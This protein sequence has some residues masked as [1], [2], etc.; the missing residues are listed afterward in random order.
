M[1]VICPNGINAEEIWNH[2]NSGPKPIQKLSESKEKQVLR[3]GP[4][5]IRKT[6]YALASFN[7]LVKL[8]HEG[9]PVERPLMLIEEGIPTL[10]T[11]F[12]SGEDYEK[13]ILERTDIQNEMRKL[14]KS[15]YSFNAHGY[16][17]PDSHPKNFILNDA[18]KSEAVRIDVNQIYKQFSKESWENKQEEFLADCLTD[19]RD[20]FL[21]P[22]A[23]YLT[24]KKSTELFEPLV[25]QFLNGYNKD[26]SSKLVVS[27][28][29]QGFMEVI[30]NMI[31]EAERTGEDVLAIYRKIILEKIKKGEIKKI[32]IFDK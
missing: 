12:V 28:I 25:Y 2:I 1:N 16:I 13:I 10:V 29:K 17:L 20:G 24:N 6:P 19:I 31:E 18:P 3:V 15:L 5:V 8:Y 14:G 26:E 9:L 22:I 4:Y 32:T 27:C 11:E 7:A 23:H 30:R 21:I